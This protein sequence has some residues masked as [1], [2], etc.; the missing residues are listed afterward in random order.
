MRGIVD[1]TGRGGKVKD[2]VETATI[3]RLTNILLQQLEARLIPKMRN[4]RQSARQQVVGRDN[5]VAF[6]QQKIA[7][8]GSDKTRAARH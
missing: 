8:V 5:G 1:G 7:E 4:V 2:V 6:P 3:E